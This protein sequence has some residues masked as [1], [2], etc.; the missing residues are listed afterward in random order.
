M[1]FAQAWWPA[2]NFPGQAFHQVMRIL[3]GVLKA[4]MARAMRRLGVRL[5]HR[6]ILRSLCVRS[7]TCSRLEALSDQALE[8][9]FFDI[10]GKLPLQIPAGSTQHSTLKA[11]GLKDFEH[12]IAP[13][14]L[15]DRVGIN[16][17]IEGGLT[18]G[19]KFNMIY[20][21][22]PNNPNSPPIRDDF[23]NPI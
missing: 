18:D 8:Q 22:L 12:F 11:K 13:E 7:P 6:T 14:K 16:G 2:R 21:A 19:P 1:T 4:L 20:T 10:F 15:G 23:H 5:A 3:H 17:R 9:V